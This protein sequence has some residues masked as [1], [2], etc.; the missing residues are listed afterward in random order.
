LIAGSLDRITAFSVSIISPCSLTAAPNR[1]FSRG[2][3]GRCDD[4][5]CRVS[6]CA[7]CRSLA[8]ARALL[9][10]ATAA[11]S[12]P[13]AGITPVIFSDP[14]GD[15]GTA[16]DVTS[17]S[18][19]RRGRTYSFDVGFATPLVPTSVVDIYL[20]TDLNAATG[21]RR[22]SARTTWSRTSK[23]TTASVSTNGTEPSGT[24]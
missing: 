14:V 18:V 13:A 24:S 6:Q 23:R 21:D 11:S 2:A 12:R 5:N 9:V 17:V 8:V 20:D 4:A 22:R 10:L 3:A 19:E 15:G 1:A 16:A 7:A